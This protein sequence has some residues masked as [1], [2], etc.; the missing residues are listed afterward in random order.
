[1]VLPDGSSPT[2]DAVRRGQTSDTALRSL[3]QPLVEQRE[4]GCS[5]TFVFAAADAPA[6]GLYLS[7]PQQDMAMTRPMT[8]L[9]SSDL[10]VATVDGPADLHLLYAFSPAPPS[11][12]LT[13]DQVHSDPE[14][15]SVQIKDAIST[16]VPDPRNPWSVTLDIGGGSL[17]TSVLRG[18]GVP[19]LQRLLPGDRASR[20]AE[21]VRT[22][23][24]FGS[25][26]TREVWLYPP[27]DDAAEADLLVLLDGQN[28]DRAGVPRTLLELQRVGELPPT[29]VV[30]VHSRDL[31]ARVADL[32]YNDDLVIFLRDQVVPWA[33]QQVR[34]SSD[35]GRRVIAG[36]SLGGSASCHLAMRLPDVF[37][38]AVAMS[39]AV[40]VEHQG[41]AAWL[42]DELR[43]A[44][45]LPQRVDISIGLLEDM[46]IPT[47]RQLA[48]ILRDRGV[49]VT[50]DEYS[51]AHDMAGWTPQLVTSLRVSQPAAHG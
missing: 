3:D 6:V 50:Y 45:T 30:F 10:W 13:E 49:D 14:S 35:V 26:D 27:A 16:L 25:E 39:P 44:A 36:A 15:T 18:P 9:D 28:F 32:M 23:L 37:G 42:L 5:Y 31:V 38:R 2:V 29:A 4:E 51:G 33:E 20:P 11:A 48:E 40:F 43:T 19:D 8:R 34:I 22:E 12:G 17:T 24:P 7:A 41:R 1:M 21:L 47:V 46:M